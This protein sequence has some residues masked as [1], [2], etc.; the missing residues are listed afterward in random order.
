MQKNRSLDFLKRNKRD[1]Y[2][3]LIGIILVLVL[4]YFFVNSTT[5][6]VNHVDSALE[7]DGGN[8]SGGARFDLDGLKKI[9]I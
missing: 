3:I 4:I 7:V 6:L 9:G 8:A 1:I 2:F 5:F